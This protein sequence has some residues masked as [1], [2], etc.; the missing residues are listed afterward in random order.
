LKESLR[1]V[2]N[3]PE[4]AAK[5]KSLIAEVEQK[6]NSRQK[7]RPDLQTKFTVPPEGTDQAGFEL[8]D[9]P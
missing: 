8:T 6:L 3:S 4:E 9:L 5:V 2:K 7:L 1:E